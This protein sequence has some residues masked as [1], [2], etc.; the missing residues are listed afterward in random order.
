MILN[1]TKTLANGV[2]IPSADGHTDW[3]EPVADEQY[4]A[5]V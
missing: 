1:Q 2:E 3:C 5:L 4:D